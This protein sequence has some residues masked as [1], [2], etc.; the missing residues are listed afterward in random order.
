MREVQPTTSPKAKRSFTFYLNLDFFPN[1]GVWHKNHDALNPGDAGSA[2]T[3][4]PNPNLVAL[5]PLYGG[6]LEGRLFRSNPDAT[7]GVFENIASIYYKKI[8][9]RANTR[10]RKNRSEKLKSRSQLPLWL[11]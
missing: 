10:I 3:K 9:M 6:F 11:S 4:G 8:V 2:L 7:K 5:A 1:L